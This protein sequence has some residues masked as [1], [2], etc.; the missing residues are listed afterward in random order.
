MKEHS[1]KIEA[2]DGLDSL[3]EL[4][5]DPSVHYT[6]RCPGG[7]KAVNRTCV[8]KGAPVNQPLHSNLSLALSQLR[9]RVIGR[10]GRAK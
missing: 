8:A 5:E 3:E 7:T 9:D 1:E 10:K 2:L 4:H 6:R